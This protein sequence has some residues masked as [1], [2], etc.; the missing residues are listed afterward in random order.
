MTKYVEFLKSVK[1]PEPSD[2]LRFPET[3]QFGRYRS[4]FPHELWYFPAKMNTYLARYLVLKYSKPNEKVLDPFAGAFT[5]PIIAGLEGRIGIGV[6][7]VPDFCMYAGVAKDRARKTLGFK[8]TLIYLGDSR[9]LSTIIKEHIPVDV[10]ITSPPYEGQVDD[11]RDLERD[12]ARLRVMGYDPKEYIRLTQAKWHY[13]ERSS[14]NL[15]WITG[16]NYRK[17]MRKVMSEMW[18]VLKDDGLAVIVIKNSIRGGELYRNDL[19]MAY[20]MKLSKFEIVDHILFEI[21]STSIWRHIWEKRG[22][23]SVDLKYEHI[24]VFKKKSG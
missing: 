17:G 15:G 6:E 7:I 4:I 16:R 20:L 2:I 18:K 13:G 23:F 24:L 22:L 3:R 10:I 9:Q 12:A 8:D 14:R 21:P 5:I 11:K 1:L 19:L